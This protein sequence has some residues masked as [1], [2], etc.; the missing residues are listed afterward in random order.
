MTHWSD[1]MWTELNEQPIDRQLV[2][3]GEWITYMTQVLLPELGA[4]RR[5]NVLKLV[6]EEPGGSAV[7]AAKLG[8]RRS[9]IVRLIDEGKAARRAEASRAESVL[10][11]E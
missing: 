5:E 3:A 2:T 4:R 9:T 7:V 8:M 6:E 10:V 1:E 11:S